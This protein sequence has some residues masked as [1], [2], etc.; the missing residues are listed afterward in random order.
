MDATLTLAFSSHRSETLPLAAAL[1]AEHDVIVVEEPPS[2]AFNRMLRGDLALAD[3]LLATDY[4]YPLFAAQACRILQDLHGR[5]CRIVPCE[6]FMERLIRI[7]DHLSD[8]GRPDALAADARLWPVYQAERE[9][10][11]RLLAFYRA[12]AE[13]DFDAMTVTAAAFAEADAARFVL[14]DRLRAA[15]IAERL[16]GDQGR[17]YIE[18]GYLHLR[19]LRELRRRWP[20]AAGIKPVYLLRQF[21]R[22]A[23][24][25]SHLYGPGDLLTLGW[26]FDRPASA[27]RQRLLAARSL[28]YNQLI[29][30]EEVMPEDGRFPDAQEDLAVIRYVN[31]LS[32]DDC[33]RLYPRI[34]GKSYHASRAAAGLAATHSDSR[35]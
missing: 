17:V 27:D 16:T 15:A 8:G 28:V 29:V 25:H 22:K 14:R 9:A 7:H 35:S 4:E 21:Y 32:L 33:R 18:A 13:R 26:I 23:G 10:T 30:K 31:R 20:A 12:S 19:L 1:M 11:G 6:P 5:G 24:Q 3:Y 2:R 34:A